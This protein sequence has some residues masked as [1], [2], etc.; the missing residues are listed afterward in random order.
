MNIWGYLSPTAAQVITSEADNSR[1]SAEGF[2]AY[3]A[4]FVLLWWV[5]VCV[6]KCHKMHTEVRGQLAR[7][8]SLSTKWVLE[9]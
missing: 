3:S 1:H 5:C 6:Y 4:G 7:P 2:G 9:Y 8:G